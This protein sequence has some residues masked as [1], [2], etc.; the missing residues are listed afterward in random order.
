MQE[1]LWNLR[2]GETIREAQRDAGTAAQK[3][4]DASARARDLEAAV[5]RLT[6]AC[7]ALWEIARERW[8]ITDDELLA[9]M[10]AIDLRDGRRDGKIGARVLK[11]AKCG[12]T[13]NSSH[14]R[15][16]FCGE[17]APREHVFR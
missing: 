10:E 1:F 7:Q 17:A 3:A 5:E 4:S 9:K 15:C 2:A 8:E 13:M 16:V 11:C 12:R 6:L 14:A